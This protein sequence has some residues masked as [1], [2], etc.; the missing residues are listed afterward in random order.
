[1][2]CVL[3]TA[4]AA[5]PALQQELDPIFT[6]Y[7]AGDQDVVARMLVSSHD[8]RRLRVLDGR[9][10]ERWLGAWSQVKADFLVELIDRASA[11]APAYVRSLIAKGQAYVVSR[12]PTGSSAQDDAIER[13]WH[14]IAVGVLQQRLMG[15]EIVNYVD[16]LQTRRP[17]PVAAAV[18]DSRINLA[19][20]IGQEQVCR[21]LHATARHDRLLSEFEGKA[22]TPPAVRQMAI[23]CMQTALRFLESAASR[24][25]VRDEART[26]AGFAA[27]QLGKHEDAR[28]A[29]QSASGG[30]DRP[31]AY[32]RA[33]FL[34]RASDALGADADAERAYSE[35]IRLYPDA[36]T[37][38][39][40]LALA[41]SRLHRDDDAEAA[42][43]AARR[44]RADG[45]DPWD[46]YFEG[47]AR[48]VG[49]WI[50]A[51]RKAR[52]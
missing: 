50:A 44:V 47:D 14:L 16:V 30:A 36:Q 38:R 52:K 9:R 5:A 40:G 31:L 4:P 28:A 8:F 1:M 25:E 7:S 41:L 43:L 35:A 49:D 21:S 27:F 11:V 6:A 26:R 20:G 12:G 10:L 18:W 39:I 2:L 34:G 15:P 23:E 22:A 46:T 13:R 19:R 24:D 37:P 33:L 42:V 29:L 32:W 45:V 3:S 51:M 48:F 17:L